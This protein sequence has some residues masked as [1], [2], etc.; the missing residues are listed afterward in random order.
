MKQAAI[1]RQ[2]LREFG[3]EKDFT[4]FQ[5]NRLTF[6]I[7]SIRLDYEASPKF[8][9]YINNHRS[10]VENFLNSLDYESKTEMINFFLIEAIWH[11]AVAD[12]KRIKNEK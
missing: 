4:V 11:Y 2:F 7:L 8:T 3:K 1:K 6:D 9:D 5:K 10:E 12:Y